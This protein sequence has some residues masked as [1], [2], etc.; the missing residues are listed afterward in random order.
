MII[1]QPVSAFMQHFYLVNIPRMP[2]KVHGWLS[3]Q[4]IHP[5]HSRMKDRK[6]HNRPGYART[7]SVRLPYGLMLPP[8]QWTQRFI[9]STFGAVSWDS[10][11]LNINIK[12][13]FPNRY[14]KCSMTYVRAWATL[15][16][17]PSERIKYHVAFVLTKMMPWCTIHMIQCGKTRKKKTHQ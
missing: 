5:S 16:W 12:V 13:H 9:T 11:N 14:L 10:L 17:F 3:T 1:L 6:M 15:I 8:Y 4:L 7:S 2:L